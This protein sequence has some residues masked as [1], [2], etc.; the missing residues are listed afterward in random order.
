MRCQVFMLIGW[1]H[2]LPTE[3]LEL[4]S[5]FQFSSSLFHISLRPPW[6]PQSSLQES[7]LD[8]K[9]PHFFEAAGQLVRCPPSD[10][11]V[12]VTPGLKAFPSSLIDN[13]A[14][15]RTFLPGR[16][17]TT[18]P[19]P[20]IS[21]F[22]H[23]RKSEDS[24]G[25]GGAEGRLGNDRVLRALDSADRW[26]GGYDRQQSWLSVNSLPFCVT[27]DERSPSSSTDFVANVVVQPSQRATSPFVAVRFDGKTVFSSS[28]TTIQC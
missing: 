22:R 3:G 19:L 6:Q 18:P 16:A 26:R 23:P 21:I 24:W 13:N 11:Y 20:W 25:N 4:G 7:S 2:L 28:V 5:F 1:W 8:S 10:G 12:G 14:L 9:K 15:A 27:V 17:D